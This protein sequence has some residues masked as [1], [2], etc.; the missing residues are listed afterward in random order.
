MRMTL[1]AGIS[2]TYRLA[3]LSRR[4]FSLVEVLV[5]IAVFG[6]IAGAAYAALTHGFLVMRLEQEDR[7]ATQILLQKSETVRLCTWAQIN[8][9]GIVPATFT[10]PFDPAYTNTGLIYTGRVT[11]AKPEGVSYSNEL[12]VVTVRLNW[13]SGRL[14]RER[15]MKTYIAQHGLQ[16][17]ID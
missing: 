8:S 9:N 15:E 10:A 13:N 16:T 5:A 7:R 2:G 14:A 11:I 3:Q 4:A 6:V 1:K 17:Y 12:R